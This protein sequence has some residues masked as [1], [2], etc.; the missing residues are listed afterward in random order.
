MPLLGSVCSSAG[1]AIVTCVAGSTFASD[2]YQRNYM[3]LGK[4]TS[5]QKKN[6][7]VLL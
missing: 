2:D 1:V 5:S 4:S 3:Q 6:K 7:L